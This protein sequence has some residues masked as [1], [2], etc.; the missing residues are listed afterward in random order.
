MRRDNFKCQSCGR[1]L[2]ADS[3]TILQVHHNT[4]WAS[5]GE[6]L[7]GNLQILYSVCNIGKSNL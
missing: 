1:L 4:A 6:T 2:A 3:G 5:V 7:Y